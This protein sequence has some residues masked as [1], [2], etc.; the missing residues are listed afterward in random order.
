M[1]KGLSDDAIWNK[2]KLRA[3][4]L[5]ENINSLGASQPLE[6]FGLVPC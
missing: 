5:E 4:A 6:V 1:Y 2:N 3:T